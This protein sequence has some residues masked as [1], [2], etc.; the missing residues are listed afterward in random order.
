MTVRDI[1]SWSTIIA[2]YSQGGCGEE[3]FELLSWMRREGPKPTEFA[4]SSVLSVCGSM[5]ILDQG[6]QI[7]TYALTVGL[8]QT[9]MIRSALINMYSKC[10]SIAEAEKSFSMSEN[11]DIVSWTAMINGYAEHGYSQEAIGI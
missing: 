3:A 8:D 7:H 4:L 11:D 6:R 5:A 2:G 1:I 9:A 10:G